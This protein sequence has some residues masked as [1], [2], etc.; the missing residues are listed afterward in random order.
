MGLSPPSLLV[1]LFVT[2]VL[3]HP[4]TNQP[5]KR[6]VNLEA[7]RLSGGGSYVSVPSTSKRSLRPNK[8]VTN[9]ETAIAFLGKTFP[10]TSFRLIDD[11]YTGDNGVEHFYFKQLAN[12]LDID[13]SNLN[14]NVRYSAEALEQ[15]LTLLVGKRWDNHFLRPQSIYRSHS[16]SKKFGKARFRRP[17]NGT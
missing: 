10:T 9:L 11:H 3:T 13:N 2:L 7:F 16:F 8:R 14:I 6:S 5:Q 15:P 12:N 17:S 4:H 1:L